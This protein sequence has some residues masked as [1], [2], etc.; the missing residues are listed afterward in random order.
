MLRRV[1]AAE[2]SWLEVTV[3]GD[4]IAAAEQAYDRECVERAEAMLARTG[5]RAKWGP[6]ELGRK[7]APALRKR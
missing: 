7:R 4:T 1:G 5:R 3:A 2:G 6:N